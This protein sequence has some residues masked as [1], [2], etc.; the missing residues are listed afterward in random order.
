[1]YFFTNDRKRHEF[2]SV[3]PFFQNLQLLN[4]ITK[5]VKRIF[6]K[7]NYKRTKE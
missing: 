1:M 2:M 7:I 4:G 6:G 5:S 3:F